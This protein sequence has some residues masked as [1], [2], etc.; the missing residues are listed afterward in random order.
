[1]KNMKNTNIPW[2]GYVPEN[3]ELK[4]IKYK[5]LYLIY[6][7]YFRNYNKFTAL[8]K[9]YIYSINF[10]IDFIINNNKQYIIENKKKMKKSSVFLYY[11]N[12]FKD[13][14]ANKRQLN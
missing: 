14:I 12:K 11:L 6:K 9:N 2:L 5:H 1:M 8:K 4:K 3:W 7:S 13:K 10:D